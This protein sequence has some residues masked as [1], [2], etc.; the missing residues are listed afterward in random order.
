MTSVAWI[1]ELASIGEDDT[2]GSRRRGASRHESSRNNNV[3]ADAISEFSDAE[4]VTRVRQGDER[5]FETLH[6][7]YARRLIAF[8]GERIHRAS[9]AEEIVQDLFFTVWL[10]RETWHVHGSVA[11]YLYAAARNRALHHLDRERVAARWTEEQAQQAIAYEP[12]ASESMDP[13]TSLEMSDLA[14]VVAR[15]I[16][17]MTP[18][19]RET[20]LLSRRH[21]LAYTEIATITGV[22]VKTVESHMTSAFRLLRQALRRI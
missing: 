21:G 5:A 18:R 12:A 4:L 8:V 13:Q 10:R 15:V 6:R 14:R 20:F 2:D 11:T 9:V 17:T 7:S 16:S 3:S 1:L 22:S 19:V